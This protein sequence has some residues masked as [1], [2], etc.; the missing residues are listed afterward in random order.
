MYDAYAGV[1]NNP[2]N[3]PPYLPGLPTTAARRIG[4]RRSGA[5]KTIKVI[6]EPKALFRPKAHEAG[7]AGPGLAEGHEFG[8]AVAQ[9]LLD[10]RKNDPDAR[11]DGYAASMARGAHRLTRTIR[12]RLFTRPTNGAKSKCFACYRSMGLLPSTAA[13]QR[14][15]YPGTPRIG[16]AKEIAPELMGTVPFK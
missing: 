7:L 15:V 8:I 10:D 9:K 14:R 4:G 11:D 6:P 16:A 13:G 3:L 5:C 12:P 1:I 2:A